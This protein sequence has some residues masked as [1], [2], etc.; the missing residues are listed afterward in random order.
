MSSKRIAHELGF[1]Q[2]SRE[3]FLA[4]DVFAG[5]DRIEDHPAVPMIGRGDDHRVHI[6]IGQQ[7]PII[8][9]GLDLGVAAAFDTY[10][11]SESS[12]AAGTVLANFD[13][14]TQKSAQ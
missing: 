12:L 10:T 5:F 6:W 13:V 11:G 3:A 1:L 4:I 14:R 7:F 9:V 8:H 2:G